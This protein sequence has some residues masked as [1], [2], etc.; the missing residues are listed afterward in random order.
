MFFSPTC[1]HCRQME[2]VLED[3]AREYSQSVDFMRL[4][5]LRFSWLAERYGVMATPTF[6]WFCGG[7]SIQSRVGAVLPVMLKKMV[8]EMVQHGEEC[9]MRSTDIDYEISGYG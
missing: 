9:R 8:E 6:L 4:N 3:L 5:T 7:K 2:P 1:P